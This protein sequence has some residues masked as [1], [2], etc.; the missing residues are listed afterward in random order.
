MKFVSWAELLC[1]WQSISHSVH[2]GLSSSVTLDQILVDVRYG[3]DVIGHLPWWED[4]LSSLLDPLLLS[5]SLDPLESSLLNSIGVIFTWSST[6]VFFSW[7]SLTSPLLDPLLESSSL[8]L[9]YFLVWVSCH[10]VLFFLLPVL[11]G[12]HWFLSV[13][14]LFL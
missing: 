2:H 10:C 6:E 5:S 9:S 12:T 14:L 13:F 7:L 1:N 11:S 8:S 3:V 4:G